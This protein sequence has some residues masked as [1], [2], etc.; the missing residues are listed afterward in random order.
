M[1]YLCQV[2]HKLEAFQLPKFLENSHDQ[3]NFLKIDPLL[4]GNHE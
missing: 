1:T 2:Q 4:L 3:L